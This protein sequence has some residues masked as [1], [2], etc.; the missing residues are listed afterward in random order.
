LMLDTLNGK[1]NIARAL[2]IFA[3]RTGA[4][5]PPQNLNDL[6]QL[7]VTALRK[8]VDEWMGTGRCWTDPN[9]PAAHPD[10]LLAHVARAE[11]R[12]IFLQFTTSRTSH[13][14][15]KCTHPRCGTYFTLSKSR[16][17]VVQDAVCPRHRGHQRIFAKR[18]KLRAAAVQAAAKATLSWPKLSEETRAKYKC[19]KDYIAARVRRFGLGGKWVTRNRE[20]IRKRE[21]QIARLQPGR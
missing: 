13:L 2:E 8:L 5:S 19:E 10:G 18:K 7:H 15:A 1:R 17:V 3:L 21:E 9:H 4:S 12:R 11:A 6:S 16:E 20:E 14:I